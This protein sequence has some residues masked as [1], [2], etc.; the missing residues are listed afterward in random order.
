ML[1]GN[2]TTLSADETVD[3]M[4]KEAE[5]IINL[6]Q[7]MNPATE[8]GA[9][10]A[11]EPNSYWKIR[12]NALSQYHQQRM[13]EEENELI[14][15]GILCVLAIVSLVIVLYYLQKT[16]W[17]DA[18]HIVNITGLIL[19]IHGTIILVLMAKTDEQLTAAVCILGAVAVYLFG[20]IR[21]S[22][23]RETAQRKDER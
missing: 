19:I 3:R 1:F 4:L 21:R 2:L 13:K 22:E 20:T 9:Q 5:M 14:E 7:E 11:L 18:D 23:V 6:T 10:V 15:V 8:K 16:S 17:F 12:M